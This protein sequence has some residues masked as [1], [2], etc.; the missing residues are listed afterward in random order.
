MR[1][2]KAYKNILEDVGFPTYQL[3]RFP[4]T[5]TYSQSIMSDP[6]KDAFQRT[7]SK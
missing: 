7:Q 5:N 6:E 1:S 3:D 4:N 2:F